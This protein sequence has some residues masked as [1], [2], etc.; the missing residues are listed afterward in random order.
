[1]PDNPTDGPAQPQEQVPFT[2]QETPAADPAPA[3]PAKPSLEETVAK[4]GEDVATFKKENE[5][6]RAAWNRR[7]NEVRQGRIAAQE[8]ARLRAATAQPATAPAGTYLDP[9]TEPAQPTAPQVTAQDLAAAQ[10]QVETGGMREDLATLKFKAEFPD[11][12]WSSI[13]EI[14]RDP[15]TQ[16]QVATFH[17]LSQEP[18]VYRSLVNAH[19]LDRLRKLD[20]ADKLTAENKGK[21]LET[22]AGEKRLGTISGSPGGGSPSDEGFISYKELHAMTSDEILKKFG[23]KGLPINQDNPPILGTVK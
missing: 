10:A 9:G 6:L 23:G 15:V 17:A 11:H 2:G 13:E 7:D 20:A 5:N 14:I 18:D 3:E 21:R 1:M 4:M 16:A 22:Q 8:L 19:N 12:D